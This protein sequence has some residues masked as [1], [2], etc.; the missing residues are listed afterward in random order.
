MALT[1]RMLKA[2]GIE[3]EKIDQIIDAHSETVDALKSERD[4]LKEKADKLDK[5]ESELAELKEATK[6]GG[7]YDRLKAEFDEFKAKVKEE[8]ETSA[9]RT[10]LTQLAKDAGLS[11]AGIAKAVKYTDLASITLD[12]KG[13]VKDAKAL[14]KSLREE[15][16]EHI[17]T[18]NVNGVNTPTP[19]ANNG[20]SIK[21]KEE[22]MAIKDT[23]ERQ[24]LIA[25]NHELFGF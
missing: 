18:T 3:E 1:R 9:K 21:T 22:I 12:D 14:I 19:P 11:E 20:K 8:K 2:M 17:K 16:A 13:E 24:K 7:D 25:E 4:S 6:D 10:A 5:V 23:A 15:W